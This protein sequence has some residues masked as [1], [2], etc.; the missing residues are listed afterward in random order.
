MTYEDIKEIYDDIIELWGEEVGGNIIVA[1]HNAPKVD[2]SFD[3]FARRYCVACGGNWVAMVYAGLK[4]ICPTVAA[5]I[6]DNIEQPFKEF[7]TLHNI[8]YLLGVHEVE[9]PPS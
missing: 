7:A 9:I 8:A 6:P 5:L 4:N 3:E 1:I 2:I